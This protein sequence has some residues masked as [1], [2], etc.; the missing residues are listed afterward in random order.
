M[1]DIYNI[2]YNETLF[3]KK[4]EVLEDGMMIPKIEFDVYYKL[5]LTNLV[6]LNLS[7]C[8]NNKIDISIPIKLEGNIDIYNPN[9]GYYNDLCYKATSDLGTDI[10]LKDRKIEFI[11][12]NKTICQDNCIFSKYDINIQKVK[13]I[14]NIPD[15]S[16]KFEKIKINKT[17]LLNN[18][19]D[20]RNIANINLLVCYKVLL[21]KKGIIKNYGSYSLIFIITIHFIIIIIFYF[22]NYFH[23]IK[24]KIK[25]IIYNR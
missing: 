24:D 11:K 19:I 2:S 10:T 15:S 25:E 5:N 7:Y 4:I 3:M 17:K 9:S 20:I 8:I 12:N 14:C 6:K 22:K 18:F 23:K 13:C 21:T 16:D 1:K